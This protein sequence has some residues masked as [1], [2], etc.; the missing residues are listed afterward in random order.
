[1]FPGGSNEVWRSSRHPPY[2]L[3][4]GSRKGFAQLA[5][6]NQYTIIPMSCIGMEDM[7]MSVYDIPASLFFYLMGDKKRAKQGDTIPLLLPSFKFQKQYFYFSEPIE[8]AGLDM[9]DP[10][11]VIEVRN[12]TK[13]RI[14]QGIQILFSIREQ[15]PHRFISFSDYIL[16]KRHLV[17]SSVV[18]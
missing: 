3:Q 15:D 8:T 4:W 2:S 17:S 1:M 14:E 5:L 11:V 12:E 6:E 10:Q 16:G 9:D 13:R 7:W 18:Q